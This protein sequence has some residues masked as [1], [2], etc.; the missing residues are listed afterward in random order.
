[1]QQDASTESSERIRRK[2][3]GGVSETLFR[4]C[5][6][7]FKEKDLQILTVFPGISKKTTNNE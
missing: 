2:G 4:N 1:M 6:M 7:V 5:H 3:S